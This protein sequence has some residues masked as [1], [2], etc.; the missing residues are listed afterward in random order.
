MIKVKGFLKEDIKEVNA[1][2]NRVVE[3]GNAFPQE[4]PF[5]EKSGMRL[6]EVIFSEIPNAKVASMSG[7]SH[8]EEVG[9]GMPTTNVVAHSDVEIAEYIQDIYMSPN[10]RVYTTDDIIYNKTVY[11]YKQ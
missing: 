3:D 2:W 9:I 4:I 1:V 11:R 8:A 7:P 10:F 5:D 6:S